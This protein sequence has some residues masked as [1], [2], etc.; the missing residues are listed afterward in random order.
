MQSIISEFAESV[1]LSHKHYFL[2]LIVDS[3]YTL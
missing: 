3:N 2:V 1:F